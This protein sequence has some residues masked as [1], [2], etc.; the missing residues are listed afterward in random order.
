MTPRPAAPPA[1]ASGP[2]GRGRPPGGSTLAAIRLAMSTGVLALYGAV[3][4]WRGRA[5]GVPPVPPDRLRMLTTLA[6]ALT[7]FVVAG[8][9]GLRLRLASV[10]AGRR[11]TLTI[12][13]LALGEAAALFAA[14]VYLQGG[15]PTLLGVGLLAFV[16]ALVA[17]RPARDG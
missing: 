9:L 2:P 8:V 1:A 4:W 12:I 17:T 5:E 16:V 13:M 11:T 15:P 6:T 14:V 3:W 7:A 10:P